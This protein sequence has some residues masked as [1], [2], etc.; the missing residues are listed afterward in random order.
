[1]SAVGRNRDS[2]MLRL[3]SHDLAIALALALAAPA[4][5]ALAQQPMQ[6]MPPCANELLPLRQKVEADGALVK[7]AFEKK[8]RAEICNA[9]KRFTVTEAKFVKYMEE[10][11][12]W[13]GVPPEVVPQLKKNQAQAIKLRGQACSG[14]PAPGAGRPALP[15]GPGLS[16]ALG[17][18][19]APTGKA[20][21][22]TGTFDTLTGPSV[23]Q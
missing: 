6:Q 5:T 2:P 12:A 15:A 3:R 10:N 22:G 13:C 1:M 9:L 20:K 23:Q 14:G 19:R 17:T 8:D 18:S 16:D 7:A 21:S 11:G 4:G